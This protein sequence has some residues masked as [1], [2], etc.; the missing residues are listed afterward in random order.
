M[1][2]L[3]AA[4]QARGL[5][6]ALV[7]GRAC[8]MLPALA[9]ARSITSADVSQIMGKAKDLHG[10]VLSPLNKKYIGPLEKN[11]DQLTKLPFVFL[12]GNHSSGKST[13]INYL[14]QSTV[15]S[16]GVAPTDDCFTIIAP[17]L[18]DTDQDGPALVGD[19]DMGF[20]G[21]RS[22]GPDLIHH[23]QLKVRQ[24]M[25]ISDFMLVDSPGMIDS[26]ISADYND[27]NA[28]QNDR[29]YDFEAVTRW[30]AERADV[31]LLFF[32]PDKPGTT[33]ETLKVLTKSLNGID[34]KL[35]IVLNKVDQFRKIHDFARAYGSL[36]WNLSKV[37][38]RKDLPRIY[39]MFVPVK[40]QQGGQPPALGS[41]LTDLEVSREELVEEVFKAPERRIDNVVTR[42]YNSTCLL[43][44]HTKVAEGIRKDYNK[45]VWSHRFFSLIAATT[46][47]GFIAS[48]IVTEAPWQFVTTVGLLGVGGFAGT[49]W[50]GNQMIAQKEK[51][52]LTDSGLDSFFEQQYMRQIAEG[53]EFT[54]AMWRR[55]RPHLRVAL[56]TLGFSDLPSLK[57]RD[58]REMEAIVDDEVP[59][60]RRLA[61]PLPPGTFFSSV[62]ELLDGKPEEPEPKAGGGVAHLISGGKPGEGKP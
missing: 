41:A 30:Y 32:D 9:Q 22:Y 15:Q 54:S 49:V 43:Q 16:T 44:M 34:H 4:C 37:I 45:Q 53:D 60:L 3:A 48:A 11:H 20:A 23:T 36:C 5:R 29:G 57:S 56:T 46:G 7:T 61:A 18:E 35:H 13:F 58:I 27:L 2:R 50:Y 10:D 24:G 12:L 33:G 17:G 8:G 62:S 42:L 31:V 59:R 19:P 55:V 6:R 21:L 14:T 25:A 51:F 28:R 1:F 47:S 52:I 26:P 38:P 39:T 40:H